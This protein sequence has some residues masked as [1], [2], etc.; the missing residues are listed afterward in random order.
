M[1]E[2]AAW[3]KDGVR[4]RDLIAASVAMITDGRFSGAR[5]GPCIGHVVP[6]A[7]SGGP[8]AV[9]REGDRIRIDIPA[10]RLGLLVP[11][12]EI[13]RRLQ[14]WWPRPLRITGGFMDVCRGIMAGAEEGAV[15]EA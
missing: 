5:R 12:E 9:V 14:E 13:A 10:R 11:E 1:R 7:A 3:I 8:I 6:E 15:W 2:M 4:L